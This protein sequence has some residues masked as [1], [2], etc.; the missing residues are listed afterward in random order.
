MRWIIGDIHGMLRPLRAL[1]ASV[2]AADPAAQ[3]YFV[4]DYV[5]RGPDSRGVIELLLS[6]PH[7]RFVR[8][9]HDDI[10]DLLLH[11][12]SYNPHADARNPVGAFTWF[13]RHGLRET[14]VSYGVD[15]I[16]I[17]RVAR[18]PSDDG[19]RS[20]VE[21]VPQSHRT[22]LRTLPPV[23]EETDFFVAHAWW[24][25]DE[26]D[27]Q[28]SIEARLLTSAKSRHQVLWGRYTY[29]LTRTKRWRRTGYFGHTPVETYPP[30]AR[31]GENLPI[32]APQ[33]VLLDTGAALSMNGRL[34]AVSA[35]DGQLIQV[36]RLGN[37]ASEHGG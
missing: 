21:S 18:R 2:R 22:F 17:E 13:I 9:N 20:L 24:D 30:L 36:D 15:E 16:D 37:A 33:I 7:A 5:N 35:D 4:G 25:P 11:G 28:P 27:D 1:L 14:L 31:K 3:F 12:K 23:V 26:P 10:F 34:S 32:R 29:E 19:V 6:L 8:G